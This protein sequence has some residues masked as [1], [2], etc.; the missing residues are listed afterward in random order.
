M[1]GDIKT[2][3]KQIAQEYAQVLFIGTLIA[4]VLTLV[5]GASSVQPFVYSYSISTA[6]YAFSRLTIYLSNRKTIFNQG[7][8]VVI[9]SVV[10]VLLGSY[11]LGRNPVELIQHQP[12]GLIATTLTALIFGSVISY[13]FYTRY[14]LIES[15]HILQKESL[16]RTDQE[17]RLIETELKLLQ[18]QIEPHFLF[19]TLSNIMS[20]IDSDHDKAKKML[21]SLTGYLRG[22]LKRSREAV[23]TLGDEVDLIDNYLSIQKIRMD[24]RLNYEFIVDS[25]LRSQSLPPLLIQPLVENAI[26]HGLETKPNGGNVVITVKHDR[27]LLTIEVLDNG[28]GFSELS[29]QGVGLKNVRERLQALYGEQAKLDLR[30]PVDGGVCATVSLPMTSPQYKVQ[31]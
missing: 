12:Q 10:G 27:G 8:A 3:V 23:T 11:I 25:S 28:L 22:N 20:L 21:A 7:A 30:Q 31:T 5:M 26:L 9:G 14:R 4:I 6:I 24:D 15:K 2:E 17:K 16:K 13:Y 18:A 1:Q 19:N 29:R